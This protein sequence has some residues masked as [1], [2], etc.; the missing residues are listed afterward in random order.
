VCVTHSGTGAI[1]VCVFFFRTSLSWPRCIQLLRAEGYRTITSSYY[2]G[3]N[4]I[5]LTFDV[6]DR[7]SFERLVLPS[8]YVRVALCVSCVRVGVG[9]GSEFG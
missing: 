8:L 7:S 9:V 1:S 5:M 2:R 6:A 3:A 4:I